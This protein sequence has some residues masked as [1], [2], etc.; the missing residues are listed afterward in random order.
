MQKWLTVLTRK[1]K[2]TACLKTKCVFYIFFWES[3]HRQRASWGAK[4]FSP[5]SSAPASRSQRCTWW[6]WK[7]CRRWRSRPPERIP[8]RRAADGP[9]ASCG[10]TGWPASPG[11]VCDKPG[12]TTDT[13]RPPEECRFCLRGFG[14]GEISSPL[15]TRRPGSTR[16]CRTRGISLECGASSG[17][18]FGRLWT[19]PRCGKVWWRP[20]RR[21]PCRSC[22]RKNQRHSVKRL[23]PGNLY[24]SHKA[25]QSR[26]CQNY[27]KF[28]TAT[29]HSVIRS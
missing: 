21:G 13:S 7:G 15:R 4:T 10:R 20:P 5:S 14:S 17:G 25:R 26:S 22:L 1:W 11:S 16:S 2:S 8:S 9:A 19:S 6:W 3:D 12:N 29:W 23:L 28:R 24:I 18:A 27:V